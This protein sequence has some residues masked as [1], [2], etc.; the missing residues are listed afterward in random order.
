MSDKSRIRS[1][2]IVLHL[3]R[4]YYDAILRGEKTK[5]Y[6][7]LDKWFKRFQGKRWMIFDYGYPKAWS[8][9]RLITEIKELIVEKEYLVIRFKSYG[10]MG[11]EEFENLKSRLYPIE[12]VKVECRLGISATPYREGLRV[13]GRD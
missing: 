6:R 7:R 10:E 5:E 2:V 13:S 1:D 4:K 3:F 12:A 8:R 11:K 9:K